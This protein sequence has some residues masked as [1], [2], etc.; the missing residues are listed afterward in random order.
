MEDLLD[1]LLAA[2]PRAVQLQK[3]LIQAWEEAPISRAI[4]AGVDAFETHGPPMSPPMPWRG[5][6]PR[7]ARPRE[8]PRQSRGPDQQ[9]LAVSSSVQGDAG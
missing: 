6:S 8:T 1:K 7:T 2:E 5:S 9:A 3:A 4:T